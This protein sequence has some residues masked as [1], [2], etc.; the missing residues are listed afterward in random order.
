MKTSNP[1]TGAKTSKFALAAGLNIQAVKTGERLSDETI[2]QLEV[3]SQTNKFKLNGL[4]GSLM[5]VIAGDRVKIFVTGAPTMDG[6]YIIAKASKEDSSAAKLASPTKRSEGGSLIFNYAGVWSRMTQATIDAVELSGKA[7]I[8]AGVA[9]ASDAGTVYVDHKTFYDLVEIDGIDSENPLV[10]GEESFVQAF[11]LI[12]VTT[13]PVDLSK[14]SLEKKGR[15]AVAKVEKTEAP[16]A[17]EAP[18]F[19]EGE[20]A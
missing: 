9:I 15:K 6:R 13:V 16:E 4:A 5:N 3:A 1:T 12:N 2:A 7:L 20:E 11:A 14:E 8:E 18:E 17:P 19:N 10:V